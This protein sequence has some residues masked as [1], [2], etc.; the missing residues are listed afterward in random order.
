M[1]KQQSAEKNQHRYTSSRL[2]HIISSLP[3]AFLSLISKRDKKLIVFCGMHC[4]CFNS[5]SKHLFLHFLKNEPDY[6]VKFVVNDDEKRHALIEQYGNHFI[7]TRTKEGKKIAIQ[8]AAW[9]VSWLDLPLGGLFLR[10]RR[11]VLHLGHGIL[12]KGLGFTEKDGHLIKKLYYFLNKSNITCSLA[13][14]D[15]MS[16]LVA[17]SMGT[18]TRRTIIAGQPY[19]D[20]LFNEP[21]KLP[22][23][24]KNDF[25]IL[26]APTWRKHSEVKLFPF[27]DF[28]FT[29][30]ENYLIQNNIH[31]YV[32]FHPAYEETIPQDI[33]KMKNV[34]LFSAKKYTEVMDYINIFDALITD[35]SSIYL[36]YMPLERPMLFLPYDLEEELKTSGFVMDYMEN[37]PGLKPSTQAE[38]IDALDKIKNCPQQFYDSIHELN[39]KLNTYPKNCC[40][41]VAAKIKEKLN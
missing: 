27:A 29:A 7:D 23:I 13:T 16:K 39:L 31:I 25:K 33:L 8:A 35:Y 37:T 22:E 21:V 20:A 10:F 19:T 24:N 3:Y 30:L 5:N 6:T 36:D 4:D 38:F 14:S 26:Y 12:L 40:V 32:R 11:Y 28:D 9:V 15:F 2:H 1:N 18:S 17:K 34:S 41:Q